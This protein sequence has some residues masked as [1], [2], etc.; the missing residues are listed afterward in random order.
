MKKIIG[1]LLL[2]C[3]IALTVVV[4]LRIWGIHTISFGNVL[5]SGATLA[6][7]AMLTVVLLIIYGLFIRNHKKGYSGQKGNHRAQPKL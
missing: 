1:L 2:L 7:L 3:S 4:I 6:L 5:R